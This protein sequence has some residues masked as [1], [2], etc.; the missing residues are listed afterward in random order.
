[1]YRPQNR[2]IRCDSLLYS[3]FACAYKLL[4][5][6]SESPARHTAASTPTACL[7]RWNEMY[8]G[9]WNAEY[10]GRSRRLAGMRPVFIVCACREHFLF[11]IGKKFPASIDCWGFFVIIKLILPPNAEACYALVFQ[12]QLHSEKNIAIS[13]RQR[14]VSSSRQAHRKKDSARR[15]GLAESFCIQGL[16]SP[17]GC[18]FHSSPLEQRVGAA[19]GVALHVLIEGAL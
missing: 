7:C 1:M 10:R 18:F 13:D 4:G 19:H 12:W 15:F 16:F 17:L 9:T 14:A 6:T 2:L 8:Y 3:A 5:S 11:L